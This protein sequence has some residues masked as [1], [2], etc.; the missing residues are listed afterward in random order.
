[1]S[2]Q[3]TGPV[4][5]LLISVVIAYVHCVHAMQACTQWRV[6]L[7]KHIFSIN[8]TH[9]SLPCYSDKQVALCIFYPCN[10]TP[11]VHFVHARYTHVG[12]IRNAPNACYDRLGT[13]T[14]SVLRRLCPLSEVPLNFFRAI[15]T[16]HYVHA[17]HVHNVGC[18][19]SRN[20][21]V[22]HTFQNVEVADGL[23]TRT[24]AR[25]RT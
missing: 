8:L 3:N 25:T 21:E 22:G 14:F 10:D 9:S 1:M 5:C 6:I 20:V 19:C 11:K 12:R 7:A 18:M 13:G 15:M 16:A 2:K 23:H 4:V 17:R 24:H